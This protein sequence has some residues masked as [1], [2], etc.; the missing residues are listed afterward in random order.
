MPFC[1]MTRRHLLQGTAASALATT[2]PGRAAFAKDTVV[3]FIYVG[4]QRRLRLQPGACRG[5]RRAEEHARRH[6]R[7]GGERPETIDVQKTMESMINLDGATLIFP[8]SFGYFDPHM[9]KMRR[10][11]SRRAVP[12][13]GGLWTRAST[14]RTPAP[15]SAISDEASTSN[16]IVAGHSTKIEKLGFVAAKPIPQVLLNINSFMLGAR[17]RRS[18]RDHLQVIFTGEWSL[19]VKEAEATNA[20]STR[21]STSSPATSTARRW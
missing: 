12:P 11:V 8:T 10:Q 5:R 4:P 18:G 6:R 20:W 15:I 21:A 19:P 3:G 9:L 13:C 16:G 1:K 14:R 17:S 2:L 7:R